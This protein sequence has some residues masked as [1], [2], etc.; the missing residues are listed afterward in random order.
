MPDPAPVKRACDACHRRKVKCIGEGL[1]VCRNCRQAGLKCTYNAIP[2]KKGPKGCRAKV[3]SELRENQRRTTSLSKST[4]EP[5]I[6]SHSPPPSLSPS[7]SRYSES[8]SP[9]LIDSCVDF[10]F[11]NLYPTQ[12]ILDRD[13]LQ[14]TISIMYESVEAWCLVASLCAYMLIQPNMELAPGVHGE[15]ESDLG[16]NLEW[17]KRLLAETIEVRKGCNY[18][19]FPTLDS[20][21]ISFFFFGSNFCLEKHNLAWFHLRE[22]TTLALFLGMHHEDT[23]LQIDAVEAKLSRRLFWVLFVTER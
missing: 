13:R 8:L 17:G 19:E 6:G 9:Q 10:F 22:A 16:S 1:L 20:V 21:T 3:I 5:S 23:Y 18:V 2:Q 4:Q 15:H 7:S 11:D 12:P 14:C